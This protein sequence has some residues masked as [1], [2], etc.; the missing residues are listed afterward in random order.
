MGCAAAPIV[1][2]P[3][4]QR[5]ELVIAGSGDDRAAIEQQVAQLNLGRRVR[6]VGRVGGATKTWLLQNALCQVVP[7]RGW[8]AFPLVVLEAY[9]AGRPVIGSAIPGLE[10]V[11]IDRETGL[12]FQ[13][14]SEAGLAAAMKQV[15][16]D[17]DWTQKAG[18][19]ARAS[20][21]LRMGSHCQAS[22]G[23]L[24]AVYQLARLTSEFDPAG[25][26]L[27]CG[28]G[29]GGNQ[30]R[31]GST[32]LLMSLRPSCWPISAGSGA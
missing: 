31:R 25:D 32:L 30:N 26:T 23:T 28:W 19:A 20:G 15:R 9:A 5:V 8:E 17:F 2:L 14:E 12:L 18:A 29:C 6:I 11:V 24:P 10:D 27:G 21:A 4:T 16:D 3:E 22:S 7:S 1:L 13:S